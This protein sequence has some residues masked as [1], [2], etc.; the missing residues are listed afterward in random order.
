MDVHS[1]SVIRLRKPTTHKGFSSLILLN[2]IAC[3]G[4]SALGHRSPFPAP[5]LMSLMLRTDHRQPLQ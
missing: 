1:L 4:A 2:G 5:A 3:H